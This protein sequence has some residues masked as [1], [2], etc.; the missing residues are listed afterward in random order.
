[1]KKLLLTAL[2]LSASF[3]IHAATLSFATEATYP[4]FE[5]VESSGKITGY[6]IDIMNAVC[7]QIKTKC[8]ISNAPFD[9]LIPSLNIGKYDAIISALS[10]TPQ[11]EKVVA[12][13]QPYYLVTITVIAPKASHLELNATSLKGKTIGVQGD[14]TF[15]QYLKAKYG[16]VV[17]INTYKSQESAFAD[18]TNGRV[19]AVM[20]DTPL[21]AAWL[22]QSNNAQEYVYVGAPISDV[23]YF[24]P[25]Y[26][27]AVKKTNTKLSTQLNA[28]LDAIKQ[29]GEYQKINHKWFGN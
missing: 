18:L 21:N 10:I 15:Y 9:S 1:M 29:N 6:D 17:K 7:A 14:T 4:P 13:T 25:G 20:G 26:G 19:D 8:T 5:S 11:R 12:F 27:I 24:G 23:T 3:S 22:K 28:A 2:M 16:S